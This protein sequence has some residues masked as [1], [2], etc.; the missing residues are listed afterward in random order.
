M[1]HHAGHAWMRRVWPSTAMN[2]FPDIMED[3]SCGVARCLRVVDTVLRS[4]QD[5]VNEQM[6]RNLL[7]LL[8]VPGTWYLARHVY[9]I[10]R[11]L[12]SRSV[13]LYVL[14]YLQH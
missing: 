12:T 8:Y 7:V 5:Q 4:A 10:N 14:L 13:A 1:T 11:Q 2:A 6:R 9:V 3:E